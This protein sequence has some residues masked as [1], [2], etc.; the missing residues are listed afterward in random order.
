MRIGFALHMDGRQLVSD[1]LSPIKCE[2]GRGCYVQFPSVSSYGP[3]WQILPSKD[4]VLGDW[5]L[6]RLRLLSD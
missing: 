3:F 2:G 6:S 5:L 1:R 4:T